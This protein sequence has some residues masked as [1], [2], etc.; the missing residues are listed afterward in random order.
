M[1]T[2]LSLIKIN[3]IFTSFFFLTVL[4]LYSN[5]TSFDIN[6]PNETK[7]YELE[8][9]ELY[10][11]TFKLNIYCEIYTIVCAGHPMS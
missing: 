8:P 10:T 11:Q 6:I 2:G 1:H 4:T 5:S 9:N 3:V 7:C